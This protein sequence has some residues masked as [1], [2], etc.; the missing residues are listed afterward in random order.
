MS[1]VSAQQLRKRYGGHSALDGFDLSLET[2]R[3]VGLIGPN[4]CGKTTALKTLMGLCRP[5]AGSLSVLDQ[6]PAKDR[7]QLMEQAAYIADVGILP[8][9]MKVRDLLRF[10]DSAHPAFSL[11]LAQQRLAHTDIKQASRVRS[12][13]KGMTV[14]LHLAIVM[15]CDTDLLVLD[16]PTLGLD[17]LYRRTF[18][19][20]LL[21]DY[22]NDQRSIL[23]TTHEVSEIEHILTDV[24]FMHRGKAVLTTPIESIPERFC[25]VVAAR[26][27]DDALAELKPLNQRQTLQGTT[28]IYDGVKR[29]D[30]EPL[31]EVSTPNLADLFVAVVGAMQ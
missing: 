1:L 18:Y 10:V 31:G 11:E 15:A 30:L 19:D 4:G 20:T 6:D 3:I 23:I 24:V 16:E 26:G 9:W 27:A 21:N 13:S 8:G 17:I 22:F 25:T 5:D 2:G 12:L 28:A 7:A 29:G 14:Q